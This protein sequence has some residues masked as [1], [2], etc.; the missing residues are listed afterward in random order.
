MAEGPAPGR[1]ARTW[2]LLILFVVLVTALA[3]ALILRQPFDTPAP[4]VPIQI[5][6]TPWRVAETVDLLLRTDPPEAG[7]IISL[8]LLAPGAHQPQIEGVTP[9]FFGLSGVQIPWLAPE[10]QEP[11][12]GL[13]AA[14]GARY[15][16]LDFS[17]RRIEPQPGQYD[18]TGTDRVVAL[19]KQYGLRLVPMLLYT[20]IWAS[21]APYAPLDYHRAPPTDYGDYREFVYQVVNRYKP[22]GTSRLTADGFGISDWVIWNEPNARSRQE[23]PGPGSFWTGTIE[24][25]SLLLRAGYEGAHA[26]DPGCNVLNGALADVFWAENDLD[27]I[28]ALE[29]L[30]D[31][32]RDGNAQDGGRPFFDTLNVHTYQLGEPDEAWYRERIE[33][34]QQVMERFGDAQKPIWITETGYGSIEIPV[35]GV[36]YL[37][38]Q[39][40]A[41]AVRLIFETCAGYSRVE[42]VFWWS[43]RDY[44]VNATAANQAMEAHYGLVRSSFEPKPAYLRY[45]QLTG[46]LDKIVTLT[47]VTDVTGA[48]SIQVP[49]SF[50]DQEGIYV[51]FVKLDGIAPVLVATYEASASGAGSN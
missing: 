30:Y 20:P 21:T 23:S 49:A 47:G 33:A 51:A 28:T 26:A 2:L 41:D 24:E 6:T 16:G 25:Y 45:G 9:E 39:A 8:T 18:W 44:Y 11:E 43:L 12:M 17:W 15:I 50:V 34:I 13:A 7:K 48:A 4:P 10:Y 32:N 42:R 1:F 22:H 46:H 27:L 29:R 31:P 38:E 3:V 5:Q 36:P 40:Q 19:A 35:P 37:D 14:S